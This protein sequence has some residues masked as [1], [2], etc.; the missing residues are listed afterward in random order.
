[1]KMKFMSQKNESDEIRGIIAAISPVPLSEDID[2]LLD[3]EPDRRRRKEHKDW[4]ERVNSLM[5]AYNNAYG[6]NYTLR[7]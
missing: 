3:N 5:T 1:M 4:I 2:Q 7:K 6:K